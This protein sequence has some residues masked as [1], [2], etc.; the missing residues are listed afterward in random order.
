MLRF[1]LN[2]KVMIVTTNGAFCGFL[3]LATNEFIYMTNVY[4]YDG[5]PLRDM[6]IDRD[7]ILGYSIWEDEKE[8][9]QAKIIKFKKRSLN[10]ETRSNS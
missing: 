8:K 2:K 5:S 1:P 3:I 6:F 7:K 9:K 4:T 10:H